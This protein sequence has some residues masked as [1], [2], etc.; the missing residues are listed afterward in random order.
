MHIFSLWAA[1]L[2]YNQDV[3]RAGLAGPY[4]QRL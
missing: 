3:L 4:K 2:P 1:C